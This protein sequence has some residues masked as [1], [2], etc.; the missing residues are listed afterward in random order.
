MARVSGINKVYGAR[1]G[2]AGRHL[3]SERWRSER[4]RFPV[5]RSARCNQLMLTRRWVRV[6]FFTVRV[7]VD[8]CDCD[9][10]LRRLNCHSAR[11][12]VISPPSL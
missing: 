9:G 2:R 12:L 5:R 1:G 8:A 6:V 10:N 3:V 4:F 7:S 11:S